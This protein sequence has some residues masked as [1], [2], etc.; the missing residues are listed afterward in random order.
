MLAP[1]M[2]NPGA[3]TFSSVVH[4][5]NEWLLWM[6]DAGETAWPGGGSYADWHASRMSTIRRASLVIKFTRLLNSA[7]IRLSITLACVCA[8]RVSPD[9]YEQA[10]SYAIALMLYATAILLGISVGYTATHELLLLLLSKVMGRIG[11][12]YASLR[13][14]PAM[15]VVAIQFITIAMYT[16]VVDPTSRTFQ[17]TNP[18]RCTCGGITCPPLTTGQS[19]AWCG[20][21]GGRV[22]GQEQAMLLF[23]IGGT[24]IMSLLVQ[25]L[26]YLD[27]AQP[28]PL[29]RNGEKVLLRETVRTGTDV[30]YVIDSHIEHVPSS[31]QVQIGSTERPKQTPRRQSARNEH[32]GRKGSETP[33][34]PE[35]R[36][37]SGLTTVTLDA[38]PGEKQESIEL[39]GLRERVGETVVVQTPT[40]AVR[41]R[42][43]AKGAE[44]SLGRMLLCDIYGGCRAWSNFWLERTDNL[45]GGTVL[46][47]LFVLSFLPLQNIQSMV[48][49]N[50]NFG[51]IISAKTQRDHFV[52]DLLS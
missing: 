32:S 40:G 25:A 13:L 30:V 23:L 11:G 17:V 1:W 3:L 21:I 35:A 9:V 45:I 39:K 50:R 12:A 51:A 37:V 47:C 19:T 16:F 10:P 38:K 8:L 26:S 33:G 5:L 48:L 29:F 20:L 2:F 52:E 34:G 28:Q 27:W 36:R 49:F 6:D 42:N 24:A 18:D 31:R 7:S 14:L 46:L 4:C 43:V 44:P 41:F 15:L 22:R